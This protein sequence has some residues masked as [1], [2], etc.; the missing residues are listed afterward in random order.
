MPLHGPP[1]SHTTDNQYTST[2][3][4]KTIMLPYCVRWKLLNS[5][6][7]SAGRFLLPVCW[8]HQNSSWVLG[9]VPKEKSNSHMHLY[10]GS[11]PARV[12]ERLFGWSLCTWAYVLEWSCCVCE[13]PVSPSL[14]CLFVDCQRCCYE[15]RTLFFLWNGSVASLAR[16][17]T[18]ICTLI[19]ESLGLRSQAFRI[20]FPG[21]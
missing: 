7:L 3:S 1:A 8:P 21:Q 16:E 6:G 14:F 10:Q 4:I 2:V 12:S 13:L 20:S 5:S 11:V 17:I 18:C 19:L 15:T 9:R